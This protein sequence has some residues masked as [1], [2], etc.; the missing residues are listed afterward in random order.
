MAGLMTVKEAC[1]LDRICADYEESRNAIEH[2][3][4]M[5]KQGTTQKWCLSSDL[6]NLQ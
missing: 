6:D 3:G 4:W 1:L 5:I 2:L